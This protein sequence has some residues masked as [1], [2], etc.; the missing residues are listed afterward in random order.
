MS[1]LMMPL[2]VFGLLVC[3]VVSAK[4]PA[5]ECLEA[6]DGIAPFYVTKVAGA[7]NDGVEQG[8]ELCYRCKYGSRPMVMV[9]A[10]DTSGKLNQLVKRIDAAVQAN[11]EAQLKGLVTLLGD[12][13][14]TLKDRAAKVAK[15]SG[16]KL[17][18]VVVAKDN[19][20]GPSSYKIDKDAA[21]TVVLAN[22]S[23]VVA[24]KSFASAD[25]VDIAAVMKVVKKMVN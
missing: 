20:S 6:G 10:R 16:A 1:R 15:K 12:D 25:K 14:S 3:S 24:T 21:I 2:A 4:G 7:E 22:N 18:P 5:S 19:K 8:E 23:K 13:V 17:V 9:F 11:E